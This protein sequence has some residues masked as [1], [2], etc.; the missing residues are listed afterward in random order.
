[1]GASVILGVAGSVGVGD[2]GAAQLNIIPPMIAASTIIDNQ[3]EN[4]CDFIF[5][6]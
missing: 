6:S 2:A 5:A 3:R 4:I 1:V